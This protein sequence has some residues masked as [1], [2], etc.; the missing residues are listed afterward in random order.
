M[1]LSSTTTPTLKSMPPGTE[2][3]PEW[4]PRAV[5]AEYLGV[6]GTTLGNWEEAGVFPRAVRFS[7]KSIRYR[8][9]DLLTWLREREGA[10]H[11]SA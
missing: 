11:G 10:T 6:T 3:W 4:V 2:D 8:R 1:S 7:P 5:V 9:D